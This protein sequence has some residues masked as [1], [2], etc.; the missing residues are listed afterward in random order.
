MKRAMFEHDFWSPNWEYDRSTPWMGGTGY[1]SI[2]PT[3]D[4]I[5]ALHAVVEEITGKPVERA[6]ARRIG[7]F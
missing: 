4:V 1:G 3:D 2:K 7:F 6:P 5:D